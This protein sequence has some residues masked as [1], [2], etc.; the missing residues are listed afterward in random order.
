MDF[1]LRIFT[2]Q[3]LL[4]LYL[5]I[6]LLASR[7][8]IFSFVFL[9]TFVSY[10]IFSQLLKLFLT[11]P[12]FFIR[13]PYSSSFPKI[14]CF[15]PLCLEMIFLFLIHLLTGPDMKNFDFSEHFQVPTILFGHD[16]KIYHFFRLNLMNFNL[17]YKASMRWFQL[18]RFSYS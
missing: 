12:S 9:L 5:I 11:I 16:D 8:F 6:G 13:P 18:L 14:S 15:N 7:Q 1:K 2:S 17:D 4:T 10:L 3:V